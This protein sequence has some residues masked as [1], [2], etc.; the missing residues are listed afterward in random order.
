MITIINYGAGNLASIQNMLRFLNVDCEITG[1][2]QTISRAKK[3]ILPGVGAFDH[4]MQRL[5][6]LDLIEVLNQ[7]VLAE[8]IPILGICL[9]VQ[10]FTKRS[11]EGTLSGLG[12]IDAETVRF[13]QSSLAKNDRVPHMGWRDVEINQASRLAK[14]LPANSR[15]YFVHSYHLRC[16]S[17]EDV[18]FSARYGYSFPSGVEK[19]NIYGVQF[20]PEKSHRFGKKLLANYAALN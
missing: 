18:L 3:L 13:N 14:E 7:K 6:E 11:D 1:D 9:G 10:L 2:P 20:H 4:G 5:H 12:W 17:P 19:E 8:K 15:F 16:N